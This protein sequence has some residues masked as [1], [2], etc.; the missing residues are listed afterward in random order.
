LTSSEVIAFISTDNMTNKLRP[1]ANLWKIEWCSRLI[2]EECNANGRPHWLDLSGLALLFPREVA[3]SE[4]EI[5]ARHNDL[6]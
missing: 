5:V 1:S 3:V 6:W 2:F 4:C